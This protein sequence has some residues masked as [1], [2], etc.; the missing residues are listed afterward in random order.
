M[1]LFSDYPCCVLFFF[2]VFPFHYICF[3]SL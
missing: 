1:N 3:Y 2:F